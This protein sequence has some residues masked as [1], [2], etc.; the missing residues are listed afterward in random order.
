MEHVNTGILVPFLQSQNQQF[1]RSLFL[2]I[3]VLFSR[4]WKQEWCE[5]QLCQKELSSSLKLLITEC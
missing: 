3:F 5:C 1:L 2:L 4:L